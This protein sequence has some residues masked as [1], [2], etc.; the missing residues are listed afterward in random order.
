MQF[1]LIHHYSDKAISDIDKKTFLIGIE[2]VSYATAFDDREDIPSELAR[3]KGILV[4]LA[5]CTTIK[6]DVY[7]ENTDI[8]QVRTSDFLYF[9]HTPDLSI[10]ENNDY[11]NSM[12]FMFESQPN[13]RYDSIENDFPRSGR[14]FFKGHM[15][16]HEVYF[17]YLEMIKEIMKEKGSDQFTYEDIIYYTRKYNKRNKSRFD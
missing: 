15:D 13:G 1:D 9:F 8:Y 16:K 17:F 5:N 3:V 4:T 12:S 10:L 2:K 14:V 6:D 7:P 11:I